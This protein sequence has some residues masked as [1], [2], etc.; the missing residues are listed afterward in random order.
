MER[1][2]SGA[3]RLANAFAPSIAMGKRDFF[4]FE[5]SHD[6]I[7]VVATSQSYSDVGSSDWEI[8]PENHEEISDTNSLEEDNMMSDEGE[9]D[10]RSQEGGASAENDGS[11]PSA[12][13]ENRRLFL[14]V[15]HV[16]TGK[17]MRSL[18]VEYHRQAFQFSTDSRILVS[19]TDTGCAIVLDLDM[20]ETANEN[21]LAGSEQIIRPSLLCHY[22]N[23]GTLAYFMKFSP[24]SSL[25]KMIST[26]ASEYAVWE[27]KTFQCI[28]CQSMNPFFRASSH[29]RSRR[30]QGILVAM[31]NNASIMMA[32]TFPTKA[33][34][35]VLEIRWINSAEVIS[36]FDCQE[37][38]KSS[39][40]SLYQTTLST[41]SE[42][43][44]IRPCRVET[45]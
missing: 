6:G 9:S 5:L 2:A 14:K 16:G 39:Q 1:F 29:P 19:I 32:G 27:T 42:G 36:T 31:I 35:T 20:A 37:Q 23:P 24:D 34:G 18:A 43:G 33:G 10:T 3:L 41:I 38:I 12:G 45:G 25:I 26:C 11:M 7:W 30:Y 40:F 22:H 28:R 21:F 4:S 15:W 17:L 44:S 13:D 8:E